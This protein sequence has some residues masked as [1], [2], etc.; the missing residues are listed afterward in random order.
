MTPSPSSGRTYQEQLQLAA[1]WLS[2]GRSSEDG[3][4][5]LNSGQASSIVN[6]AE[7]LYVLAKAKRLTSIPEIDKTVGFLR[8]AVHDH[9][10]QRG[11]FVRYFVFGI[12]GLSTLGVDV[13]DADIQYCRDNLYDAQNNGQWWS[14][15]LTR[16]FPN[17]FATCQA[18]WALSMVERSPSLNALGAMSWLLSIAKPD[19]GWG[20]SDDPG[21]PSNAA[22]TS[23]AITSLAGHFRRDP[24][25]IAGRDWLVRNSEKWKRDPLLGEILPGTD[26]THCLPAWVPGALISVNEPLSNPVFRNCVAHFESVWD[27][28]EGS[29]KVRPSH[30]PT[31]GSTFWAVVGLDAIRDALDPVALVSQQ[32]SSLIGPSR[33]P[34]VSIRGQKF[35]VPPGTTR[36]MAALV[37]VWILSVSVYAAVSRFG[38]ANISFN[39][40]EARIVSSLFAVLF[41]GASFVQLRRQ[42]HRRTTLIVIVSLA[43]AYVALIW[44]VRS[45][46]VNNALA[47]I[48][49]IIVAGQFMPRKGSDL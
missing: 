37:L 38:P 1:D 21:A 22:C 34:S 42:E 32:A 49:M 10:T 39:A 29:W 48:S 15:D 2:R 45:T 18:L 46:V 8:N 47:I 27:P 23:Y 31:V 44:L 9:P 20:F 30:V 13:D 26:W 6:T 7:A 35:T 11:N 17:V 12:I 16:S 40:L 3:G 43:V 5:G 4:W 36:T 33:A 24:K 25:V 19:G 41:A 14:Q 28:R